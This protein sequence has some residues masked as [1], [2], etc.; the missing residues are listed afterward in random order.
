MDFE[1]A[2]QTGMPT[3]VKSRGERQLN[4]AGQTQDGFLRKKSNESN[5]EPMAEL[6]WEV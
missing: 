5:E 1:V 2:S 3:G 4:Y 6:Q